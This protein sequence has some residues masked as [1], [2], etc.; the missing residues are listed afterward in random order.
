MI[1]IYRCILAEDWEENRRRWKAA[2][3]KLCGPMRSIG[4]WESVIVRKK[5][6][7]DEAICETC[8][9]LPATQSASRSS[10]D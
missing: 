8:A 7:R 1:W 4:G 5:G 2:G 10:I 3:W 6:G 9:R